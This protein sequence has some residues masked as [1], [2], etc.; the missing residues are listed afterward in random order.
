VLA[1]FGRY[2][3]PALLVLL[4]LLDGPRHGYAIGADIARLGGRWLGPGT[5]Y[6]AIGRLE[7]RG[8]IA[9]GAEAGRRTPYHLTAEGLAAATAELDR[10]GA[11]TAEARRRLE[12]RTRG[13]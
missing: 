10:L 12:L 13:A 2:S 3:E 1:E 5:L 11:L 7:A 9:A 8:L 6:G 4:S